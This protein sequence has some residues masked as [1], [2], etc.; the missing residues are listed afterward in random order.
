MLWRTDTLTFPLRGDRDKVVA[1]CRAWL[2]DP[3]QS[4]ALRV[5]K[6]AMRLA[7]AERLER[8]LD[9]SSLELGDV[10]IVNLPGEPMLE[11]QK[12]AQRSRPKDFV[13][14]AGYGDCGP[15]YLCTEQALGEGGY[16]PQASNVGP[17]SEQAL[18]AAIQ[19]LLAVAP[20]AHAGNPPEKP[21]YQNSATTS[22]EKH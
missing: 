16:E 7:F 10:W 18:R 8:P 13:A 14:V 20:T 3:S 4:D 15:A 2:N 22:Y 12:F 21:N 17:G 19:R 11:F 9:V 6:G 1:Q 5:Y